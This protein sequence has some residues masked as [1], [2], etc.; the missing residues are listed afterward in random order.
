VTLRALVNPTTAGGEVNFFDAG[1]PI[2]T[3]TLVAGVATLSVTNFTVGTHSITA[4][5]KGDACHDRSTSNQIDQVVDPAATT[6]A[7]TQDPEKT[8]CGEKVTF[9]AT[10]APPNAT[11]QVNFFDGPVQIGSGTLV[12]G[13]AT[14]SITT[15][16]VGTHSV[17]AVYKGDACHAGSSSG[18]VD[19]RVNLAPTTTVVTSDPNPSTC[20]NDKVTVTAT[21]SPAAATGIVNFFD[22]GMP[23]GS[24]PLV[25]GQLADD[26]RVPGRDA[27][28]DRDLQGRYLLCDEHV[29]S[30]RARA[31]LPGAVAADAV[32]GRAQERRSGGA[33][34]GV[35]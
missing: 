23:I 13:V 27:S 7:L 24:A 18:P 9:T 22:G 3:A 29:G 16:T 8:V 2:G 21:V 10:V 12:M 33:A 28:A 6:T 19:H 5:Y 11:G 20:L 35:R 17:T 26:P 32:P 34:L 1:M 14:L 25:N 30:P 31:R 15:L 4:A